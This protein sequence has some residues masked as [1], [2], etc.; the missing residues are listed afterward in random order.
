MPPL[1]TRVIDILDPA[2]PRIRESSGQ[3][4]EYLTLSYVWGQGKRLLNTR[5]FGRYE[6]FCDRIPSDESMPKTF[7]EAMQVTKALGYRF[8]WIDA[9]CIIQDDANDV[10]R[11]M[12]RMGDIYRLSTLTISAG[13]GPNTDSGLFAQRDARFC[14]SRNVLITMKEGNEILTGLV[15]IGVPQK[16]R[17]SPLSKRGW[18]LQEELLSRRSLVF[19]SHQ[20]EWRCTAQILSE[21]TPSRAP[22]GLTKPNEGNAMRGGSLDPICCLVRRPDIFK[23]AT[24]SHAGVR[25]NP[26]A[27]WYRIVEI[28]SRRALTV[29]SDK[30]LA[31]A[32]LASLVQE[33][34][35]GT[36]GAGLWKEDLQNGLGWYVVRH[37]AEPNVPNEAH[38]RA[39]E[40]IAPSWS[41][42]SLHGP[43]VKFCTFEQNSDFQSEESIRILDWE[44]S[45]PSG[46]MV[47][48]GHVTSARLTVKGR[49]RKALLVPC[50]DIWDYD[51]PKR[52]HYETLWCAYAVDPTTSTTIGDV[53]L[54][55]LEDYQ[56]LASRYDTA[57]EMP[58]YP[59]SDAS[60]EKHS[61]WF[62][63]KARPVTCMLYF[64]MDKYWDRSIVALVLS[65]HNLERNE[66]RRIGLLFVNSGSTYPS[67]I[68]SQATEREKA[69][70]DYETIHIV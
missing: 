1:P 44:V 40:Y 30:L 69:H 19:T 2:G 14:K 28:Y 21:E 62:L 51:S 58:R 20:V 54:D 10:Q 17:H 15:S 47:P 60:A 34:L 45:H 26:F 27:A 61:L 33:S 65:L 57:L 70:Q 64:V 48:F 50:T 37:L 16:I 6:E 35:R 46:A 49:I 25:N 12:A 18:V 53:A 68:F 67:D 13:N 5:R 32:G 41:W 7:R 52:R 36:Y 39:M 29:R 38:G 9:L 66:Y 31:V 24:W 23:Q 42:A 59:Y 43:D 3:Q 55:S 56:D 63:S 22:N 11:E 4:A 8:L